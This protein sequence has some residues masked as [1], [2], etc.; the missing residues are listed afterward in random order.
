MPGFKASKDRLTVL[1][2]ASAAGDF[3]LKTMPFA[4]LKVLGSLR[5]MLNL[6]CQGSI[7]GLQS[8]MTSHLFTAWFMEYFKSTVET[9]CSEKKI[10]F[11]TL[12]QYSLKMLMVTQE[13]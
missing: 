6:L 4:I 10:P 7:N 1:L 11:N 8:L 5:I 9:Y 2:G 12:L 13:L 3:N